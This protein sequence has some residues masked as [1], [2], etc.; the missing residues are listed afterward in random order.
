MRRVFWLGLVIAILASLL[1]V[2]IPSKSSAD[3]VV[4]GFKAKGTIV[5]GDIVAL[6]Q[7]QPNT[8]VLAPANDP[9]RIYGVAISSDQAPIT[10]ADNNSEVFVAT[11]GSYPVI[12]TNQKG[13]IHTGDY[14][15]LSSKDGIAAKADDKT[16]FVLGRALEDFK[17]T[18]NGV[19]TGKANVQISPGANPFL[20]ND[21]GVPHFLRR[22]AEG[23]AGKPLS[24]LRIYVALGMFIISVAAA[25]GL[26]AIGVKS[27]MIAIG[28]N[29][30]S[31][32][33]VMQS[34]GQVLA[35]SSAVFVTSLFGIYLL[36]RL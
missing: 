35:L 24:A 26:M 11:S 16:P 21:L 29:P 8:V 4:F 1:A 34:L 28:R 9:G 19:I 10:V 25:S 3:N 5:P 23:V 32:H 20:K 7:S 2:A 31:R 30:L 15:S 14:I 12:A 22:L 27:G 36:L 17:T 18:S 13:D 33:S 6:D